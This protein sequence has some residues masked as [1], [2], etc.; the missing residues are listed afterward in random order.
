[1]KNII[2]TIPK[3]RFKTWEVAERVL[4]RCDGETDW[5]EVDRVGTNQGKEWLWFVRLVRLP[6]AP[7]GESVCFMIYDGRVRGY[8]H[9]ISSDSAQVWIN[10]GYLLEDKPSGF[11][12]VLANWVSL[13]YSKQIEMT[14]FQGWRYTA[15]RP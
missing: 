8:F 6:K 2:A 5:D 1:M 15:L 12:I 11:V 10:K 14:G 3:G 7:L 4:R 13:P 9:I